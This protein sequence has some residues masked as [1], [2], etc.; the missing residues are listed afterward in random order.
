MNEFATLSEDSTSPKLQVGDLV[1]MT[2]VDVFETDNNGK[3]LS[4]CP[5]FDNRAVLKTTAASETLRKSS[6]KIYSQL[7]GAIQSQTATRLQNGVVHLSKMGVTAAK[8]VATTVQ[9]QLS[10]QFVQQNSTT[11]KAP[12]SGGNSGGAAAAKIEPN[13][14]NTTLKNNNRN[15]VDAAGFEQALSEAEA[16]AVT[17][18]SMAA[19]N[20]A[21]RNDS[22]ISDDSTAQ[23]I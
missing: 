12:T 8:S 3:L 17:S 15:N 13:N 20:A 16:A 10:Q 19:M 11:A 21:R 18:S 1:T 6:N 22:Y 4:Y 7:S 9:S 23:E 2:I 14:S 5:T